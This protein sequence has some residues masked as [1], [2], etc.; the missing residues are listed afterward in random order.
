MLLKRSKINTYPKLKT[1]FDMYSD[2][3]LQLLKSPDIVWE[4]GVE[5]AKLNF[6]AI[7]LVDELEKILG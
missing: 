5:P 4:I 6:S 7:I 1:P 2:F 3:L